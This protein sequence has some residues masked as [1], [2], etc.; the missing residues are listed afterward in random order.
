VKKH[1]PSGRM[2]L[3]MTFES[4]ALPQEIVLENQD[5][6]YIPPVPVTVGVYGAVFHP[7]SLQMRSNDDISDYIDLAG[8]PTDFADT[9][10]MFVVRANGEVLTA[11]NGAGSERALPGDVIFMPS[12]LHP[13]TILDDIKDYMTI[14]FQAGVTAAAVV[15]VTQ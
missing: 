14:L 6:I 1:K 9:S 4:K 10:N 15:G 8:G 7:G 13:N 5:R 12:R 3:N 2:V 11:D